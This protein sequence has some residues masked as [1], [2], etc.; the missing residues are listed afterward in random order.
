MRKI[1]SFRKLSN[2]PSF[3]ALRR[4][5]TNH[6]I[7]RYRHNLEGDSMNS[8]TLGGF[9]LLMLILNEI[10]KR[11][12][13]HHVLGVEYLMKIGKYSNTEYV[14]KSWI[15][16]AIAILGFITAFANTSNIFSTEDSDHKDKSLSL[17]YFIPRPP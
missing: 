14:V 3:D 10:D 1:Y 7:P 15:M 4:I 2:G 12:T 11:I 6:Q 17:T 8:L 5:Q 16:I 9:C 13:F